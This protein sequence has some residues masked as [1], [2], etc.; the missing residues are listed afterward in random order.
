MSCQPQTMYWLQ[1]E[2]LTDAVH[3]QS[4]EYTFNELDWSSNTVTV[5]A[6]LTL[7]AFSVSLN[8]F[9]TIFFWTR[10]YDII[11]ILN[12]PFV[13]QESIRLL[14]SVY[15][16]KS[17]AFTV[18]MCILFKSGKIPDWNMSF[19]CAACMVTTC[20]NSMRISTHWKT[21]LSA[22]TEI[23]IVEWQTTSWYTQF[24]CV[25]PV[26]FFFIFIRDNNK[27]CIC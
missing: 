5:T 8:I 19:V 3:K 21:M 13:F 22:Y 26:C 18:K 7:T 14:N 4:A 25:L 12:E 24:A 11:I 6:R 20:D 15:C 27:K 2:F 1:G 9:K 16:M 23:G 10:Y 17:A